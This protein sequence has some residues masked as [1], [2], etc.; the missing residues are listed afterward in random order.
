LKCLV[1]NL[2]P[3][4]ISTGGPPGRTAMEKSCCVRA[5]C[6]VCSQIS[7]LRFASLEMTR[8]R[9]KVSSVTRK[10]Q[11]CHNRSRRAVA[12]SRRKCRSACYR[13]KAVPTANP[14]SGF[15]DTGI[16]H[17]NDGVNKRTEQA[18]Q[19][20]NDYP[21]AG[22][23]VELADIGVDPDGDKYVDYQQEQQ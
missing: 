2:K 21:N 13:N 23:A 18:G 6:Y 10:R 3:A 5:A 17:S 15:L 19:Q 4:V 7:R 20:R 11:V 12:F 8:K 14:P 16:A 1:S 9:Q 22:A